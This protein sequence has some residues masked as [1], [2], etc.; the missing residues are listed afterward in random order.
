MLNQDFQF[1]RPLVT[2]FYALRWLKIKSE[3]WFSVG[4]T[5]GLARKIDHNIHVNRILNLEI[6]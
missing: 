1:L 4:T 2:E 5:Q 3:N 6:D